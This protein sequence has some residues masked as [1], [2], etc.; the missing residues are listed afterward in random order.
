MRLSI[1]PSFLS[2]SVPSLSPARRINLGRIAGVFAYCY[3]LCKSFILRY[4]LKGIFGFLSMLLG[5]L[6]QFLVRAGFY[7]WLGRVGGWVSKNN[8]SY[9]GSTGYRRTGFNCEKSN[10]CELQVFQSSQTFDS[11][12]YSINSPPLRAICADTI[13]KFTM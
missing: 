4:A 6:A 11:Q 9:K 5:Y 10:N 8:H 7:D 13:I 2:L 12:T 3:Y 1:R